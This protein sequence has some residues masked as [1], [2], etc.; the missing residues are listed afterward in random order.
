VYSVVDF[1]MKKIL[2]ENP[3]AASKV[4]IFSSFLMTRLAKVRLHA[5][6]RGTDHTRRSPDAAAEKK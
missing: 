1:Y 4:H 6:T 3:V 5:V 2:C